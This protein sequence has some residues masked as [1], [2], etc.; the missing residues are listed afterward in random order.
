[1]HDQ[2]PAAAE[3]QAE[4]RALRER[5]DATGREVG[6]TVAELAA[7][8]ADGADPR[9]WARR[10]AARAG[11]RAKV[12]V[13]R[14]ARLPE[15]AGRPRMTAIAVVPAVLAVTVA[16]AVLWQRRRQA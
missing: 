9:A 14:V 1:M 15:G 10:K 16:V 13:R 5:A 7:R 3:E 8:L 12:V 4:L 2:S 6:D 11:T